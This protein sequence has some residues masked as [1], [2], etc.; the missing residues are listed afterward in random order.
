MSERR[1]RE[2]KTKKRIR[3]PNT[4]EYIKEDILLLKKNDVDGKLTVRD[5]RKQLLKMQPG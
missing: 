2:P 4:K 5:I 1:L 3:G